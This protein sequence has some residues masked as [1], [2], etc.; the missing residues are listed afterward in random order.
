MSELYIDLYKLYVEEIEHE[1]IDEGYT[2]KKTDASML[3]VLNLIAN[4]D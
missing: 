4:N 3:D 1:L 2:I